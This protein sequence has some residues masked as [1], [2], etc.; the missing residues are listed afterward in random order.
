MSDDKPAKGGFCEVRYRINSAGPM[1]LINPENEHEA[2]SQTP[3]LFSGEWRAFVCRFC[4]C[5][6]EADTKK[7]GE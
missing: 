7:A 3:A 1:H 5:L 6:F 4:G 2:N